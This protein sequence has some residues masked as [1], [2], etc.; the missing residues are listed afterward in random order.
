MKDL[1]VYCQLAIQMKENYQNTTGLKSKCIRHQELIELLKKEVISIEGEKTLSK[2]S[3]H[4]FVNM[5]VCGT[6]WASEH[7]WLRQKDSDT[8]EV[9]N[10]GKTFIIHDTVSV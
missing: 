2:T 7:I 3:D 9:P 1:Y 10:S 6:T 4:Y 8:F 5:C